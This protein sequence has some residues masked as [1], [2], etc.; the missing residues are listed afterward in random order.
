M[1]THVLIL[2]V[3]IIILLYVYMR[4]DCMRK[5]MEGYVVNK[6]GNTLNIVPQGGQTEANPGQQTEYLIKCNNGNVRKLKLINPLDVYRHQ[7]GDQRYEEKYMFTNDGYNN[8]SLPVPNVFNNVE[9]AGL[10]LCNLN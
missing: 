8:Y 6:D 1:E 3:C 7:N 9:N 4:S 2:I 5:M 10:A